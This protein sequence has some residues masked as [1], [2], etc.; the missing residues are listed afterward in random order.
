VK[1]DKSR[2]PKEP[3]AAAA[4]TTSLDK[5]LKLV[6]HLIGRVCLVEHDGDY[7][8]LLL[9]AQANNT[10][11][12]RRHRPILRG[13]LDDVSQ[14]GADLGSFADENGRGHLLW[15]LD[16][17]DMD[18]GGILDP[19][20]KPVVSIDAIVDVQQAYAE[21][22]AEAKWRDKHDLVFAK[23]RPAGVRARLSLK[24][25]E[26]IDSMY[27]TEGGKLVE[28]TVPPKDP[29]DLVRVFSPG[30]FRQTTHAVIRCTARFNPNETGKPFL[31]QTSMTTRTERRLHFDDASTIQLTIS[32]LCTCVGE[33]N[34]PTKTF[35]TE[36][37]VLEDRE[38]ALYYELLT[39]PPPVPDRPVPF[40][41]EGSGA[42]G[43]PECVPPG[44]MKG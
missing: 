24:N 17:F 31:R 19:Q 11:G 41:R 16:D 13:S 3:Q 21:V 44:K 12:F 15:D 38:F 10:L 23:A 43:V 18:F 26:S 42:M 7:T 39:A 25:F 6:V 30:E 14:D 5:T 2:Q 34:P 20:K 36:E 35:G 29:K 28:G 33:P 4:S 1:R 8:A 32:N 40:V 22:N 37:H 9:D 27:F